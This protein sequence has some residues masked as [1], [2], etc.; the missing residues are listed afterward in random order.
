MEA[1]HVLAALTLPE[2][3]EQ[4]I[5][6]VSPRIKLTVTAAEKPEDIPPSTWADVDILYTRGVLPNLGMAPNL[7]WVQFNSAGVDSKLDHPI[8]QNRGIRTTTMSGAI[9]SQIAEYVLMAILALGQKL[10]QLLQFQRQHHWPPRKGKWD[11]LLP[12]E[13]RHTTVGL[14]GY[15]SIGRQVARLLKPFGGTILAVKKDVLHPEDHGYIKPGM[16]DPEGEFFDRL[17]PIEAM[18]S[19]LSE[20]DFVVVALPLTQKTRHILNAHA[21]EVMKPSAYLINVG[22]GGLIDEPALIHAIKSKQIAGAAL[23]VFE[24]EPLPAESPLWDLENVIIS[25]HVSGLSH[26]LPQETLDLFVENLKRYL[27]DLPLYNLVD[28]VQGY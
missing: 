9:T 16:G 28:Q 26:H 15:G 3:G 4:R 5:T 6:A 12:I 19:F 18:H 7:K 23:D 21:F 11:H 25:P 20:C 17:Y 22:R 27:E 8:F 13:L 24:Q 14:L 2:G 10:P 1:I